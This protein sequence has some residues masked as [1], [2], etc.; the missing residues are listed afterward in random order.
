MIVNSFGHLA[1][2][3]YACKTWH[4]SI[5]KAP[6]C[7]GTNGTYGSQ[8]NSR[9][10][11]ELENLIIPSRLPK[12][13]FCEAIRHAWQMYCTSPSVDEPPGSVA[14]YAAV[15]QVIYSL[16]IAL[17]IGH[18]E[19]WVIRQEKEELCSNFCKEMNGE[20]L[21]KQKAKSEVYFMSLLFLKFLNTY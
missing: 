2:C 10:T 3:Y 6:A 21:T 14:S 5:L 7:S 19:K 11:K 13:S 20:M 18:E 15:R 16:S 12:A 4:Q 9:S 8:T 17:D 1:C